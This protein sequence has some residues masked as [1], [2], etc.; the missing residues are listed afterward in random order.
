MRKLLFDRYLVL[1]VES[2]DKIGTRV[3]IALSH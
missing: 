3:F 2:G 1:K